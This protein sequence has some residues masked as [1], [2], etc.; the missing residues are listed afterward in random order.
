[1][2]CPAALLV[3]VVVIIANGVPD[4]PPRG[5]C[6]DADASRGGGGGADEASGHSPREPSPSSGAMPRTLNPSVSGNSPIP[7]KR[8]N[9]DEC[10][11]QGPSE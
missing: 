8:N 6:R 5:P 10:K 1:M 11:D 9:S 4:P 2:V 7:L 3:S